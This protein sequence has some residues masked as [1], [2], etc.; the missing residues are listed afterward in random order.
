MN[1][2]QIKEQCPKAWAALDSWFD[3]ENG[4][5]VVN[6]IPIGDDYYSFTPRDL[7]DF[8]DSKQICV[9]LNLNREEDTF[10]VRLRHN[11]AT[12]VWL[13]DEVGFTKDFDTRTEAES[14]AFT[15]AF[16]ILEE[17]LAA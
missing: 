16:Q 4:T 9:E 7:Y 17:R 13:K 6:M 15:R 14:A 1:W 3:E 2:Q 5:Y 8:F 10:Y 11:E 12:S